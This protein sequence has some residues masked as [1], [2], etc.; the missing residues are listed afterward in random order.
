MVA[1]S[2]REDIYDLLRPGSGPLNIR[3]DIRKGVYVEGLCEKVVEDGEQ[4]RLR[5]GC[6]C[7]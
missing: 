3:E 7:C 6:C 5:Q 4:G 2:Y 1:R